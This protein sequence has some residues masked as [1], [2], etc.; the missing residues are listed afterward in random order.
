MF[1]HMKYPEKTAN[2][3]VKLIQY[4]RNRSYDVTAS[5]AMIQVGNV[6]IDYYFS[7]LILQGLDLS[8]ALCDEN[9][10]LWIR[11]SSIDTPCMI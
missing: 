6:R 8:E 4:L 1:F 3:C 9:E 2:L 10:Y 11:Y 5:R 7:V